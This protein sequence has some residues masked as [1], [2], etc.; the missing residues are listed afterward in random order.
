MLTH[1]RRA[2][3][4]QLLL[5]M[6]LAIL[7]L[8]PAAMAIK[9][10]S[11]Q[12]RWAK[13][14][15][16]APDKEVPGFL[17]NLGPTGARGVLTERTF[18]V[19]YIFKGS[20]ALGKLKEG[21]VILG[22]SGRKFS[23]HTFGGS[24]HGCEGPIMDMGL[25]IEAA[26][27]KDGKLA[28][29][30]SRDSKNIT[31]TVELEAI[32]AFGPTYPYNCKK[33]E[34]LRARALK[35][36]A[37][38][39]DAHRGASN[40]RMAVA[41]ALLSSDNP[42]QQALGRSLAQRWSGEQPN[43]GT[44][45]WDLSHQAITLGEYYILSRDSSVLPSIKYI[46]G[47]I[48]KAQ[49]TGPNIQ[50]WKA[51]EFK[52]VDQATLDQHQAL[53]DGGFGHCPYPVVVSRGGGGYGPMQYT[54]I[55]T[56]TAR[57]MAARCSVPVDADLLKRSM[58][59]IHRGTNE[60]GYVAYGGE[61]TLNNG[62][63]DPVRWKA[64]RSGDN[65]VG[66]VGCAIVAHEL[67]PEFADSASYLV[68][69]RSFVKHAVKSMADGHADSNLGI[70]WGIMGAAAS[71]DPAALRAVLDYHKAFFNMMRCYD[72]SYVVLPGRDYADG[73]YYG[74]SRYHPTAS[75]ALAYGLAYPKL[76]IQGV[77][78]SIPGVNPKALKGSLDAA[79]KAIVKKAYRD[80]AKALVKPRPEEAET[81]KAM[82]EYIDS[83]W[84][85]NIA[86]LADIEKS[87]DILGLSES[88]A[89]LQKAYKGIE[90]FDKSVKSYEE[91]LAKDPWRKEVSTGKNYMS[92]LGVLQKY[93]S[94]S[95]A[96]KLEQF[97][98]SNADS[99]YGKWAADVVKEFTASG[100]VTVWP[101]GKP[102][103]VS[104]K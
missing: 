104:D 14:G 17:I 85:G 79:Y 103:E 37:D 43:A 75:M 92:I 55:L 28:L 99:I 54:T 93:K 64:S 94:A 76:R 66:R 34:L 12:G 67:G 44:W 90:G 48:E 101:N 13:S 32:G 95:A 22:C 18:I 31:V 80:A 83:K 2:G 26:E 39:S 23:S 19:K 50:R 36:L 59:F 96:K 88:L 71:E 84:Q 98:Q 100:T 57:Q 40:T 56:V 4:P 45:S 5:C 60:A 21:D 87:G 81:A 63:V 69:Y 6:V 51:S 8:A 7:A 15:G 65:Y 61:F 52:N 3:I 72:G 58:D 46:V 77:E 49:W 9:D 29:N 53:Y 68:K 97:A 25:A 47:L 62:P 42:S 73:G 102:F 70:F 35:Y 16:D 91:G 27:G 20:P 74:S 41:L 82:M 89:K 1:H 38:N 11:N 33:S 24:P 10:A 78:V 86:E 30:V